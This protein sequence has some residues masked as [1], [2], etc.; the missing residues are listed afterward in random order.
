MS[1]HLVSNLEGFSYTVLMSFLLFR[2]DTMMCVTFVHWAQ[3]SF[4]VTEVC[5]AS[6]VH[7]AKD[8]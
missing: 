7:I 8:V 1:D 5:V 6:V 2:V 4:V 3:V